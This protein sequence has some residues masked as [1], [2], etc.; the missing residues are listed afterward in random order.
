MS[1]CVF[2]P[3]GVKD[4]NE[5]SRDNIC[6]SDAYCNN[7][8]GSYTCTCRSGYTKQSAT[9]RTCIDIDECEDG[10]KPNEGV[11][12][13]NGTC[14]NTNGSFWCEC[15]VSGFTNYG[16]ERTPC[17]GNAPTPFCEK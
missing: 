4:T 2:P 12:G 1:L 14:R 10:A 16:N 7:T 3:H 5:C 13:I 15:P 8:I 17:S 6:G 11:C 9:S